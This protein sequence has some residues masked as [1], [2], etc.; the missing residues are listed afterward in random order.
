MLPNGE[1][2]LSEIGQD[3]EISELIRGVTGKRILDLVR[4][5]EPKQH[6]AN[7]GSVALEELLD[8]LVAESGLRKATRARFEFPLRV[9]ILLAAKDVPELRFFDGG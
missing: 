3:G 8:A 2:L 6:P 4:R 9:A 5:L 1:A 7:R